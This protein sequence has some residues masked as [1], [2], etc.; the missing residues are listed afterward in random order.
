MKTRAL[1]WGV[2][3]SANRLRN[4]FFQLSGFLERCTEFFQVY[5]DSVDFAIRPRTMSCAGIRAALLRA[6]LTGIKGAV[7]DQ[8]DRSLERRAERGVG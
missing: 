3:G 2:D 7:R 4:I 5:Q 8:T 1:P 6:A